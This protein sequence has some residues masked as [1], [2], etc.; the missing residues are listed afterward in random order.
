[1]PAASYALMPHFSPVELGMLGLAVGSMV[2]AQ[3]HARTQAQ[4]Q[5]RYLLYVVL[6][7]SSTGTG[8]SPV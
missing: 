8:M 3:G 4:A 5:A 1:M 6:L 7:D 2:Q